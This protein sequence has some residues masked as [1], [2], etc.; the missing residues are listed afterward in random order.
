MADPNADPTLV[1]IGVG[2]EDISV[3]L[4]QLSKS[5]Q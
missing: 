3:G 2:L 1:R 4:N 5:F